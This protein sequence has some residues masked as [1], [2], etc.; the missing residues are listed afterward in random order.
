MKRL[1]YLFEKV[2][3]FES[4]YRAFL[5]ARKRKSDDNSDVIN[6][7]LNLGSNLINLKRQLESKTYKPL[8]YRIFKKYEP[9][10]RL[11]RAPHFRD[12]IVHHSVCS[13]ALIPL[14]EKHFIFHTFASRKDKGQHIALDLLKKHM[15]IVWKENKDGYIL[16]CDIRKYFDNI[17]HDILKQKVR[18]LIK[19]KDLL[20]LVDVIIN[21][22]PGVKGI[23][24]GNLTSQW[25][26]N[27]YLSEM[28]H[29]IKE[30]LQIRNYIRYMDDFTLIHKNKSYL[31]YC[32]QYL[33]KYLATIGLEFNEKTQLFPL[34]NGVDF[35]GYHTYITE[36]GKAIRILRRSS[37]KRI[38]R[39]LRHFEQKYHEGDMDYKKLQLCVNSWIGHAKHGNTY[40]LRQKIFKKYKFIKKI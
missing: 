18:R 35:L 26:A 23:S 8:P 39:K 5:N 27:Y 3:D 40:N 31:N 19:D 16:K 28:D 38:K 20:W 4:L 36:T 25:L 9:K 2:C 13:N 10:K 17:R 29:I 11:I 30:K 7:E 33:K 37:K 21:S 15:Q 1:G 24:I 12:R 6:F 34:K 22:I 14:F 32:R